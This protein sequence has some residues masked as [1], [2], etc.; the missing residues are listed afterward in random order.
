[1]NASRMTLE[2]FVLATTAGAILVTLILFAVRDRAGESL[3]LALACFAAGFAANWFPLHLG[4]KTKVYV[5][6]AIFTAAAL[7]L[8]PWAAA[9]VSAGAVLLRHVLMREAWQQ[10]LFNPSQTA[11]YVG[12]GA[13][14]FS[15]FA[16]HGQ[17]TVTRDLWLAGGAFGGLIV[18]HLVNTGLVAGMVATHLGQP[19][20]QT[21]MESLAIDLPEHIALTATGVVTAGLLAQTPWI[22]PLLAAPIVVVYLSLRATLEFRAVSA[23]LAETAARLGE[24]IAPRDEDLAPGATNART[25]G[26]PLVQ[27]AIAAAAAYADRSLPR[28]VPS[29]SLDGTLSASASGD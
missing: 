8:S 17:S 5:D 21:W 9:A 16:G 6:T 10:T 29:S 25:W 7:T 24:L 13:A 2:R 11:I 22:A 27:P 3:W 23:E 12:L 15:A 20:A 14:T 26:G 18:M 4:P 19:P 1:M 28:S